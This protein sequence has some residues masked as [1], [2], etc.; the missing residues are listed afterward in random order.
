MSHV[1]SVSFLGFIVSK[2]NIEM[3]PTKVSA[4]T[5]WATPSTRKQLQRF[6]GFANFYKELQFCCWSPAF[7]DLSQH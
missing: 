1:S 6:L 3:D 4:V 7:S 5:E 2:D